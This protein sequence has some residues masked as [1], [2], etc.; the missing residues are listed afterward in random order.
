MLLTSCGLLEE[1]PPVAS[2]PPPAS[3]V[4]RNPGFEDGALPW[5]APSGVQPFAIDGEQARTATH[6]LALRADG[7][8]SAATQRLDVPEIPEFL[9]GFYRVDEWPDAGLQYLQV[10]ISVTGGDFGDT[11]PLHEV[12]IVIAGTGVAPAAPE[13]SA[14][15]FLSREE[16]EVGEWTYFSYPLRQAFNTR[17]GKT[18]ASWSE[19]RVRMEAYSQGGDGVTVWFDDLFAGPQLDNPNAPPDP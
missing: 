17:L 10:V 14:V 16:P 12:R 9:S 13:G 18:P 15:V 19:L 2:P 7:R 5:E 6:S 11:L 4:L 8:S 3:N 1:S